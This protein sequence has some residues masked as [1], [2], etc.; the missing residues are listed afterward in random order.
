MAV[1]VASRATMA[2]V[3]MKYVRAV[4]LDWD[5][6][7]PGA[8]HGEVEYAATKDQWIASPNAGPKILGSRSPVRS[9]GVHHGG[10][11]ISTLPVEPRKCE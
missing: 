10:C 9:F 1:N 8:E 4:F 7:I 11:V 2:A 3:G 5:D 6:P